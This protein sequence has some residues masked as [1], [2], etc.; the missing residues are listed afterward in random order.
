MTC[1]GTC[2]KCY[3]CSMPRASGFCGCG[4]CDPCNRC[5]GQ[6]TACSTISFTVYVSNIPNCFGSGNFSPYE[7]TKNQYNDFYK[8]VK[9]YNYFKDKNLPYVKNPINSSKHNYLKTSKKENPIESLKLNQNSKIFTLNETN[10][11]NWIYY[12]K[13]NFYDFYNNKKINYYTWDGN[14]WFFVTKNKDYK[15]KKQNTKI[16]FYV[17]FDDNLNLI[18]TDNPILN[19]YNFKSIFENNV[20]KKYIISTEVEPVKDKTNISNSSVFHRQQLNDYCTPAQICYTFNVTFSAVDPDGC[21]ICCAFVDIN[22]MAVFSVGSGCITRTNYSDEYVYLDGLVSVDV[23]D[24][25]GFSSCVQ[26]TECGQQQ[27]LYASPYS[28]ANCPCPFYSVCNPDPNLRCAPN[29]YNKNIHELRSGYRKKLD[30]QRKKPK[31]F[32]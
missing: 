3:P 26:F 19:N 10:S 18:K 5:C 14:N 9:N 30:E 21:G 28:T 2:P 31:R 17:I 25:I 22:C 20:D 13:T 32:I 12:K 8:K 27:G 16:P 1:S 7:K 11:L 15:L 24:G 6:P 4:N 23:P 29:P